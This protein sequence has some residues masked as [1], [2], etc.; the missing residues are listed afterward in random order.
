MPRVDDPNKAIE[1]EKKALNAAYGGM[2]DDRR[3]LYKK[4]YQGLVAAFYLLV[5]LALLLAPVHVLE[6]GYGS[7][8]A[9]IPLLTWYAVVLAFLGAA[10]YLAAAAWFARL[11][12]LDFDKAEKSGFFGFVFAAAASLLLTLVYGML[13]SV[14]AMLLCIA[15]GGL[16]LLLMYLDFRLFKD[17]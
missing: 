16:S 10:V 17:L 9:N 13:N 3:F 11:P 15:T 5:A 6:T 1:E 12:F 2:D 8:V 7:V 14:P 4:I